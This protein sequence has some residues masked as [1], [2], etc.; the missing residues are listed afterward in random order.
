MSNVEVTNIQI[1]TA[2]IKGKIEA[3][4]DDETM[5]E[6][7]QVFAEIIYPW[8]PYLTGALSSYEHTFI[9]AEGVTYLV[10]YSAEKYYGAVYT[11]DV[12]P[13]ATS[14]WDKVALETQMPVLKQRVLEILQARAKELYG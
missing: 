14:H 13:L 10:P 1:N 3:L 7:Q 9:S 4:L 11:K 5:R 12:H 8:T 2:A 6:I